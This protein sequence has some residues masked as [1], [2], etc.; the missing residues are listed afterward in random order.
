MDHQTV[1]LVARKVEELG[2]PTIYVGVA[3]DI[4]RQVKP[5]RAVFLNFPFGHNIGRPLDKELQMS[6]IKDALK[7]LKT[8]HEPGK[9]IDLS[10]RW[11]KGF[12]FASSKAALPPDQQPPGR[13]SDS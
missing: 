2:I 8:L 12:T 7:T 1:G 9:I 11:G 5:P 6:I 10:Y 4:M 13:R 3:R